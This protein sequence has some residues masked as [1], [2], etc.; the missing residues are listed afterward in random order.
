MKRNY[1]ALTRLC[2]IIGLMD[3]IEGEAGKICLNP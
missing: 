3:V 1:F 2:L